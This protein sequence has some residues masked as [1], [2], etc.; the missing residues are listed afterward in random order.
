MSEVRGL[1][2]I[3]DA[4]YEASEEVE[5]KL[6]DPNWYRFKGTDPVS[7]THLQ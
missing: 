5:P 6:Y 3:S 7:Y 2:T 1:F 4:F